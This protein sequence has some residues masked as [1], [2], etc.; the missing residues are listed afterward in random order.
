MLI[1]LGKQHL[2]QQDKQSHE[3]DFR[4]VASLSDEELE[5]RRAKLRLIA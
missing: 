1:W 2:G 5:D 4:D 3:I